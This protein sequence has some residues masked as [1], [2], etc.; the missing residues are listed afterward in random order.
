M[1]QENEMNFEVDLLEI[2][3]LLKRKIAVILT[4]TIIGAMLGFVTNKFFITPMYESSINMIVNTRKD[5]NTNVTND[6]ITSA[7]KM[8]NTYAII[9]KSNTVLNKVIDNLKLDTTYKEL[10][11]RVKVS[12]I[13]NTQ[14]MNISI[15]DKD[16]KLATDII[17]QIST[18]APEIIVESV[19]A[20]SCKVISEI[21]TTDEPVSPNISKNTVLIA[22]LFMIGSIGVIV[23]KELTSNYIED[24][25]DVQKKLGLPVLG[26]IPEISEVE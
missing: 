20:G 8:V 12:A 22:L 7:Q 14:V 25:Q 23:I 26:V 6:N 1:Q 4:A 21:E 17:K 9:I 19:E 5:S 18:I 13:N 16:P 24:D 3:N 11:N 10:E 2:F 15:K